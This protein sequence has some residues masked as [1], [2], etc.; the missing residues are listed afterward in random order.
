M[1]T[2]FGATA[3]GVEEL[4][5]VVDVEVRRVYED[6]GGGAGAR[7]LVDRL[8]PRGVGKDR[9]RLDGWPKELAPSTALR[10]WYGHEPARFEEFAR[11]Y[12]A[13]LDGR[14]QAVDELVC[15]S[16]G[17]IVLLT[18]TRDVEH[19]GARVLGDYIRRLAADP[20]S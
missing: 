4:M 5:T 8:W 13:E 1:R 12:T 2:L 6:D 15:A 19:S 17:R 20:T 7:V 9:L 10:R 14:R 16:G 11:R 18:A 3:A